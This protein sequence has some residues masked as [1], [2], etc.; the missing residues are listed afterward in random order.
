MSSLFVLTFMFSTPA[1]CLGLVN[2]QWV[3]LATRKLS[4]AVY[5]VLM[6]ASFVSV[7][8]AAPK[9]P[10]PVSSLLSSTES[11]ASRGSTSWR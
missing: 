11:Q 4:V 10:Q 6:V 8:L 2:P 3:G 7:G 1:F 9:Q 5:G